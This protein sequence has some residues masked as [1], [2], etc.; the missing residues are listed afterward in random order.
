[1]TLR[2][3]GVFLTR[4]WYEKRYIFYIIYIMYC[5]EHIYYINQPIGFAHKLVSGVYKPCKCYILYHPCIVE[6]DNPHS[7][8]YDR[9]TPMFYV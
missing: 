8:T 3:V 1:M 7:A 4:S 6:L 5:I 9:I 2:V